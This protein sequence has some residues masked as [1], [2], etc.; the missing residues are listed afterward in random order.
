MFAIVT[1]LFFAAA[2]AQV[3]ATLKPVLLVT[4]FRQDSLEV[5]FEITNFGPN[6]IHFMP[7]DTP[8]EGLEEDLFKVMDN[9]NFEVP[10]GG[11]H[12]MRDMQDPS[13]YLQTLAPG[14]SRSARVDLTGSYAVPVDGYVTISLRYGL[15][16]AASN[17]IV[18]QVAHTEEQENRFFSTHPE[19]DRR[20]VTRN[21]FSGC[22]SSQISTLQ[23]ARSRAQSQASNARSCV[24]SSSGPASGC[25]SVYNTWYGRFDSSRHR[26]I[27]QCWSTIRSNLPSARFVCDPNCFVVAYVRQD[28]R[29][30]TQYICNSWFRMSSSERAAVVNHEQSHFRYGGCTSDDL[31]LTPASSMSL[32]R[33]QPNQAIRNAY[34]H[35]WFG[36]NV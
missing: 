17:E 11:L 31:A 14:E 21:G 35:E 36:E 29:T 7:W 1:S 18:V 15:S 8:L 2:E 25:S 19:L 13:R 27:Q 32:A 28:D 22:S 16:D 9:D 6:E 23:S 34:N 30:M 24:R 12:I 4:D 3:I 26:S 20:H 5:D 10:Y 33:N